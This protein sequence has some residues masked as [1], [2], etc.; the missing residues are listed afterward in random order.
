MVLTCKII[1]FKWSIK[2]NIGVNKF[3]DS[4]YPHQNEFYHLRSYDEKYYNPGEIFRRL[5]EAVTTEMMTKLMNPNVEISFEDAKA[6]YLEKQNEEKKFI[7]G[8]LILG[9][10]MS[11]DYSE[12]TLKFFFFKLNSFNDSR[13]LSYP[14]SSDSPKL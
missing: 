14:N 6:V 11:S 4:T 10:D 3:E 2:C 7:D 8:L 1:F 13:E 12:V 5:F 9:L